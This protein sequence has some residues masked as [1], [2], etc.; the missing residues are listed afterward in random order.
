MS[1]NE[2]AAI[3]KWSEHIVKVDNVFAV[4]EEESLTKAAQ[5]P[6]SLS[7]TM[8]FSTE[9]NPIVILVEYAPICALCTQKI[10]NIMGYLNYELEEEEITAGLQWVQHHDAAKVGHIY[11]IMEKIN[12]ARM[13][14]SS[15]GSPLQGAK[16]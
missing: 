4:L 11:V 13:D 10:Q 2:T 15:Y 9:A 1:T 14:R 3:V 8:Q 6:K 5:L 12:P 7:K 16:I